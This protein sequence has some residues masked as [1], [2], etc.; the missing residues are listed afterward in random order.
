M[1]LE[2]GMPSGRPRKFDESVVLERAAGLFMRHGYDRVG[3]AELCEETGVPAQSLYNAFGSKAQIFRH[4]LD[5]YGDLA[6]RPII[7]SLN[8]ERD[9]MA[10]LET[11]IDRW[12][13]HIGAGPEGGCLFTQT[14]AAADDDPGRGDAEIPQRFTDE[15]RR[16]LRSRAREAHR[17]G[18]MAKDA[19]PGEIADAILGMAFGC[20]VAGR[21]GLAPSVIRSMQRAARSLLH[22]S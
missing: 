2:W 20:A 13:R 18:Q 1:D 9:P 3:I 12:D 6:N 17:A 19:N 4:A 8:A 15:L 21:G 5:R 16:A 7:E 10:A 22:A 11:F 14:L